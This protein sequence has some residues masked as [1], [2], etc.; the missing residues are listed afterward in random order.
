MALSGRPATGLQRLLPQG[1]LGGC[2]VLA[3]IVLVAY[4]PAA[5]IAS[6]RAGHAGLVAA[7]IAA[8]VC[9]LASMAALCVTHAYANT[10]SAIVAALGSILLRTAAPLAVT[11]ILVSASPEL[12][13]AGLFGSTVFFYLLTLSAETVL[14]ARLVNEACRNPVGR[15]TSDSSGSASTSTGIGRAN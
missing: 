3:A 15:S 9:L 14:A 10:P 8:G 2:A 4:P 6:G 12:A 5:W 13:A 11:V 1:P 7:A